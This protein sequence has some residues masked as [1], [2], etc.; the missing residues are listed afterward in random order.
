[1]NEVNEQTPPASGTHRN[2]VSRRGFLQGV[3]VATAATVTTT[4]FAD[5]SSATA[6]VPH[7]N[8]VSPLAHT[9]TAVEPTTPSVAIIALNKMGFGPRPGDVDA[10]NALGLTDEERMFTYIEQQLAYTPDIDQDPIYKAHHVLFHPQTTDKTL[11]QLWADHYRAEGIEHN[12]RQLPRREVERLTFLRGMYS[13]W[14]LAEMLAD[15]WHN[16][17]N[18]YAHTNPM[19]SIWV[20]FDRDVIRTHMLGNF[21]EMLEEVAKSPEM[22]YFLDNESN[23]REG[24]NE[25]FARELFELHTLGAENYYG[26]IRQDEVPLDEN[27]IPI[28]YVD[29]DVYEATRCFTGWTVSDRASDELGDTGR[30][31]YRDSD[32]DRF[33]KRV[34]NT[35]INIP[36]DQA[37]LQDGHDV[38]DLVA[39]HP[40]TAR[41][42]CRKLCR[43]FISDNPPHAL[44]ESA[45]DLFI[46]QQTAPDQ[47]KQVIRHILRS[48][49]F[50]TTWG[51]KI[52]R[53]LE[54]FISA[55]RATQANYPMSV[56]HS[57]S[58]SLVNRFND[59]GQ[60]LFHWSAPD[61]YPDT[62]TPWESS[63]SLLMRWRMLG[64]MVEERDN[65]IYNIDIAG[66]TPPHLN[67]PNDLAD[68]WIQRLLNRNMAP[69]DR[70]II[71]DFMALESEGP[72]VALDMTSSHVLGRVRTMVAL[73]LQSPNF[74]WR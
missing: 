45:A 56:D 48:N 18:I 42:I 24:P 8:H 72:D 30:F 21:R 9:E 53:P 50:R 40:G 17:F 60:E 23:T 1:M 15:F 3:G 66:Q 16:H 35:T 47:L 58:N 51:Q 73:I 43:R 61:G 34:L 70:Q 22:L 74:N 29:E 69:S 64:W 2:A 37:P 68:F 28:G 4:L 14:Q 33:Q 19:Q 62:R 39:Y 63:A 46:A 65:D 59:M 20:H 5:P 13:K 10:F 55:L 27:N 12:E 36:A 49:E 54:L 31:I 11:E 25:N 57:D 41:F 6:D 26:T 32:H 7:Y 52:K 67:T 44:V 38:L 71:V